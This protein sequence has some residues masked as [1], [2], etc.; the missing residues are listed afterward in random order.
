MRDSGRVQRKGGSRP[1]TDFD[2]RAGQAGQHT[3]AMFCCPAAVHPFHTPC[4]G[5]GEAGVLQAVHPS[6]HGHSSFPFAT[7]IRLAAGSAGPNGLP[8]HFVRSFTG[9]VWCAPRH[10][11][12]AQK[13]HPHQP[14][15]SWREPTL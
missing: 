4:E 3:P 7:I 6:L 12:A 11:P 13:H 14:T 1:R 5:A 10:P 2:D 9:F 15:L 8:P